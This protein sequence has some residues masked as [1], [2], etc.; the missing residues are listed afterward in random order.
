MISSLLYKSSYEINKY[1][2]IQIPTVREIVNNEE[3]YFSLVSAI[4]A[5][6]YD[7]MVQLDDIGIDFTTV[8]DWD[9]FLSLFE[10]LKKKD[11]SLIFNN[12]NIEDFYR[13]VNPQNGMVVL[14]NEKTNAIID[15][16]I[17][18]KICNFLRKLLQLD[19]QDKKPANEEAKKFMIERAR[20]KQNRRRRD[21]F[22]S[23]IEDVII[24]LVNTPEFPYN[25]E[26]VLDINIYQ[27]YSSLRQTNKKIS[28]DNLMIGVYAGTVNTKEIDHQELIWMANSNKK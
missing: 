22:H 19:K 8:T 13:I 5:T 2:T 25:Y 28:Y 15:K 17:Y 27:L 3:E 12:I 1:I 16:E 10:E 24:S 6:P 7:M 11:L 23:Q 20:K 26:S 14:Y 4:I 18:K 9:I 21:Q